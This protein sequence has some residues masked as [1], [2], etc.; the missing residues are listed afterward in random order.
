MIKT[1]PNGGPT[2][3]VVILACFLFAHMK[4]CLPADPH[5]DPA[6][7]VGPDRPAPAPDPGPG[8]DAPDPA[9]KPEPK[10]RPPGNRPALVLTAEEYHGNFGPNFAVVGDRIASGELATRDAILDALKE[11]AAPF[12]E[13]LGA[14]IGNACSANGTVSDKDALARLF[15]QVGDVTGAK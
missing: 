11:N 4:G 2:I 6:P 10:P 13:S 14:A 3:A 1:I 12:N 7:V 15:K 8:P 9:P 5:A